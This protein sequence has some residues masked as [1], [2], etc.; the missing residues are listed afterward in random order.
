MEDDSS[1]INK[2]IEELSSIVAKDR[3]LKE[4]LAEYSYTRKD[5]PYPGIISNNKSFTFGADYLNRNHFSESINILIIAGDILKGGKFQKASS[6]YLATSI[7]QMY[8]RTLNSYNKLLDAINN[9]NN[10]DNINDSQELQQLKYHIYQIYIDIFMFYLRQGALFIGN[11]I[12]ND[13]NLENKPDSII[14]RLIEANTI[15]CERQSE[16]AKQLL[17]DIKAV[18]KNPFSLR[19]LYHILETQC[20]LKPINS[21]E[22]KLICDVIL[23]YSSF[24]ESGN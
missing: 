22:E 12:L 14:K 3:K 5:S 20:N 2:L 21:K 9:S 19:L 13:D 8:L 24:K 23:G 10:S 15:G 16:S 11:S 4:L 18:K 1:E 7:Y 6:S 17:D